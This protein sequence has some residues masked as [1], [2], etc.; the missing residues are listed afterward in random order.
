MMKLSRQTALIA[1][2]VFIATLVLTGCIINKPAPAIPSDENVTSSLPKYTWPR[3]NDFI[4]NTDNIDP[5]QKAI[6]SWNTAGAKVITIEPDIGVVLAT[7]SAEIS[8]QKTTRYTL[9]AASELGL[10]TGWV[11]VAVTAFSD[12]KPDLVITGISYNSGLLYYTIKNKSK[13][14]AGQSN[15]YLFDQSKMHRDTSWVDGLKA[16]EEKTLPFTNFDY[17]GA[18]I[19]I[20]AD[21]GNDIDEA[22]EDNNCFVPTFGSRFTYDLAQYTT[23]ATWR[24]SAGNIYLPTESDSKNGIVRKLATATAEDGKTYTG[25]LETVPPLQSYGWIEGYFGDWQENWQLGGTMLPLELPNN[26]RFRAKAGFIQGNE[27]AAATFLIGV[28]DI[29]HNIQWLKIVKTIYDGKMDDIEIDFSGYADKKIILVLRVEQG[30]QAD[31]TSAVWIEA[32]LTQ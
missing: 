12:L 5:G 13:V 15:T 9:T 23:R 25:V 2:V 10:A 24:G 11:T 7:G 17:R 29:N 32:K 20:C 3:I 4:A 16:G 19:T 18:D 30:M 8:P 27:G 6:L 14:D 22:V 31:K 28:R 26:T 21:G 1:L